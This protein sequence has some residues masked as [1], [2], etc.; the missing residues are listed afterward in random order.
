MISTMH[1]YVKE[2]EEVE[3]F[4]NLNFP[5]IVVDIPRM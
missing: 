3:F 1:D 4:P 2:L 5:Q